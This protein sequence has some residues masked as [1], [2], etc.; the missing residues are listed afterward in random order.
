MKKSLLATICMTLVIVFCMGN[1]NAQDYQRV[2]GEPKGTAFASATTPQ[3]QLPVT[4]HRGSMTDDVEGHPSFTIN[5]PGHIPWSYYN[6]NGGPTY[7]IQTGTPPVSVEFPGSYEPM[8]FI[9]FKPSATV[10]A[11]SYPAHSGSQFFACFN[12]TSGATDAWIISPAFT[13]ENNATISFWARCLSA[14]YPEKMKVVTSTTGNLP[15][16]FT[17]TISPGASVTVGSTNWTQYTY[18][19]PADAKHVAIACISNDQFAL[20]VDDITISG[21]AVWTPDPCPAITNLQAEIQGTDVLL[22]WTAAEGNPTGYKVY[23]GVSVL[24]TVTTTQYLAKNLVGNHTLGVEALYAE[25][26]LPVKVT[27]TVNIVSGAPVKNLNGTCNDGELTLTWEAP[28]VSNDLW[29]TYAADVIDPSSGIGLQ[30]GGTFVA[31]A[32]FTPADLAERMI[33]AG[34]KITQIK[35]AMST[36]GA[37][38]PGLRIW[39]GGTSLTNAGTLL[40]SQAFDLANVNNGDWTTIDLSTPLDLDIT[41]ELRIGYTVTHTVGTF[42]ALYDFGPRVPGDKSDLIQAGGWTTVFTALGG[43]SCN[44]SIKA[45]VV[46]PDGGGATIEKYVIYKGT[47]VIG[48]STTTSFTKNN[49]PNGQNEYCVTVLY[50]DA[51][52]SPKVCKSILC[53]CPPATNLLVKFNGDCSA[54]TL[55]WNSPS[56]TSKVNI[57]RDN[58]VIASNVEGETYVDDTFVNNVGHT[59][60]VNV[61]CSNGDESTPVSKTEGICVGI[62]NNE[63]AFSIV[64]NPAASSIKITAANNFHTVEVVSFLGQTVLSQANAALEATLDVSNLTSGVYFVRIISDKGVSVQKFV[65]Q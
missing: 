45:F 17:T 49:V 56:A 29:L 37:S 28:D 64:P 47:E 16:N 31:A 14:T 21:I 20:F 54:A 53:T 12:A 30:N 36:E 9:V 1:L 40:V 33:P 46:F 51:S 6:G 22:T 19:I 50:D 34:S 35:L 61:V 59:W 4:P 62:K 38:A 60:S 11:M 58:I 5:S 42:P 25:E 10:P 43:K 48:E 2:K 24:A 7:G 39:Q 63:T 44:T 32:R 41:K 52:Q 27:T 13:V 18:N 55:T 65:K 57:R 3:P 26:C 8:A 15:A 23:D